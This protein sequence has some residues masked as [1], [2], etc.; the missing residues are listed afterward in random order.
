M[1]GGK[2]GSGSGA[3]SPKFAAIVVRRHHC[4]AT[5]LVSVTNHGRGRRLEGLR[6]KDAIAYVEGEITIER[7][8]AN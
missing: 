6:L 1:V 5:P 8:G 3:Q 4:P 7:K 2:H